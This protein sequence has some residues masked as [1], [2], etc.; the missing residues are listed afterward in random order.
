[1]TYHWTSPDS[2]RIDVTDF[3]EEPN[4]LVLKVQIAKTRRLEAIFC[5]GGYVLEI[6]DAGKCIKEVDYTI[7]AT[8]VCFMTQGN[9]IF[10]EAH[11]T[12]DNK[13]LT[14]RTI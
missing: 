8:D 5:T 9:I 1:M 13:K 11:L 7:I 3:R 2:G 10:A 4:K 6:M 12:V 14:E